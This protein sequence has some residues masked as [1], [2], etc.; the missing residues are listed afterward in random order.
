MKQRPSSN[1]LL[2]QQYDPAFILRF[3]IHCLLMGYIEAMEFCRLGLLAITFVS[4][5]STDVDLR[6][7]GYESLQNFKMALQV[8]FF[9]E[10][11]GKG[12]IKI[13]Q[14]YYPCICFPF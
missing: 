13:I 12:T 2:L 9:H 10:N 1:D 6:K 4:I 11:I 7:L 14:D 3:S 5:S 8:I